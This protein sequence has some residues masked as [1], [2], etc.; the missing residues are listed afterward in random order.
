MSQSVSAGLGSIQGTLSLVAILGFVLLYA[1]GSGPIPWVYLPEILPD[2]I[3]G[4]AAA[5]CTSGNWVANLLIG[6]TFP[7]LLSVLHIEGAYAIFAC[8][9]VG[10]VVFVWVLVVE[11]K[12]RSL[13]EISRLLMR[14][15][16]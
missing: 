6:F 4:R 1:V 15:E 14:T 12:Q 5:L 13:A 10:A 2:D 3:Q 9:N 16:D 8:I 11:T 7:A